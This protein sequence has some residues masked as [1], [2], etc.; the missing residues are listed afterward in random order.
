MSV[1]HWKESRF[2]WHQV[3][4]ESFPDGDAPVL[5]SYSFVTNAT[6]LACN[7]FKLSWEIVITL[8][9]TQSNSYDHRNH[10]YY[11]DYKVNEVK[12]SLKEKLIIEINAYVNIDICGQIL[13]LE[14]D[15]KS[16]SSVVKKMTNLTVNYSENPPLIHFK[17]QLIQK[18]RATCRVI[19]NYNHF[20]KSEK[21]CNVKLVIEDDKI[22]AHR[23]IL[24]AHSPVFASMFES[25]MVESKDGEVKI[26]D[27]EFKILKHLVNYIYYA[28]I[29]SDDMD[30]WLALIVAADKYAIESL[31]KICEDYI[32]EKLTIDNVVD[33][34]TTADLVKAEN[35][36]EVCVKFIV[37]NKAVVLKT[38]SYKKMVKT[39]TDLVS[40]M[41]S[42]I[43]LCC[44]LSLNK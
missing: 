41:F 19:E 20:I 31:V 17:V 33:V 5:K 6:D 11:F 25:D 28:E 34:F 36:K 35:L 43:M 12:V 13:D 18:D 44:S 30:D 22:P 4:L 42:Y 23:E 16:A 21:S 9:A 39:R 40:E 14:F 29:E 37:E 3:M 10:V 2:E 1:R 38:E 15:S 24:S 27:I 26:I 7:E 8:T 32:A